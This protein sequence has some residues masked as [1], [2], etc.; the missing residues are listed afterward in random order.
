M[1]R[2]EKIEEIYCYGECY[3]MAIA[4]HCEL[5]WPI[6][7]LTALRTNYATLPHPAHSW[8]EAPDG[9]AFDASGFRTEADILETYLANR[10][11]F[12]VDSARIA[13]SADQVEYMSF[14][15]HLADGGPD[16]KQWFERQM[17][18]AIPKAAD[19]IRTYLQPRYDPAALN[20]HAAEPE[21]AL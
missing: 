18:E 4:L 8:V 5:G 9:R 14:L 21:F 19:A 7:T 16:F 15:L 12:T 1:E 20:E 10:P 6:K 2:D 3:A 13:Q 11:A 17:A